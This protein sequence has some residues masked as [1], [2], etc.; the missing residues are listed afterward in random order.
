MMQ[1]HPIVV[2]LGTLATVTICT[3]I[4]IGLEYGPSYIA[5]C[6]E[7]PIKGFEVRGTKMSGQLLQT[8]AFTAALQSGSLTDR[9][10]LTIPDQD[11]TTIE[12]KKRSK[13]QCRDLTTPCT[14]STCNFFAIKSS[15][16]NTN[17]LSLENLQN[18]CQAKASLKTELCP[19]S[20]FTI[21]DAVASYNQKNCSYI[22][23]ADVD[24][25]VEALRICL[26]PYVA[27]QF[28]PTCD[29]NT[30]PHLPAPCNRAASSLYA[31]YFYFTNV[32]FR[33][34]LN[35]TNDGA[36]LIESMIVETGSLEGM[37]AY[38][39]LSSDNFEL[40]NGI[41]VQSISLGL[42][43]YEDTFA[44]YL[45]TDMIFFALA[46]AVI[47]FIMFLYLRS[48]LMVVGTV[49]SIVFAFIVAYLLYHYVFRFTFFPFLNVLSLLVLIAVGADD[50]F[51]FYDAWQTAKQH[52]YSQNPS[53]EP[54]GVENPA[55]SDLETAPHTAVN[56]SGSQSQLA[57]AAQKPHSFSVILSEFVMPEAFG[58]AI[59]SILVTS[60]TTAAAFASNYSSKIV[61]IRCFGIMGMSCILVNFVFMVTWIPA[62]VVCMELFDHNCMKV[63]ETGSCLTS[64]KQCLA[65][66]SDKIFGT[67]FPAM[68]SKAWFLWIIIFVAI[69]IWG[70]VLVFVTPTLQMP[71]SAD[72]QLFPDSNPFEKFR[73]TSE[74]YDF[75]RSKS[76]ETMHILFLFGVSDD[77]NSDHID[78]NSKATLQFVP[79]SFSSQASQISLQ[80]FCH[81]LKLQSW[82]DPNYRYIP[83]LFDTY[84]HQL[85]KPCDS[86]YP[87]QC[88]N[89]STHEIHDAFDDCFSHYVTQIEP[90][91]R[92][93]TPVYEINTNEMKAFYYSVQTTFVETNVYDDMKQWV[94]TLYNFTASNMGELNSGYFSGN[95]I[96]Y[97]LQ[98]QLGSGTWISLGISLGLSMI[99]MLITTLN[100]L[101]TIYAIFC[102]ALSIFATI[103]VLILMGWELSIVESAIL[104]L[105]V[106]LSIDFTIHYGVAYVQSSKEAQSE[107]V[108]ESFQ[109]VG[110][111]VTM[112]GLTTFVAGAMIM[113][114]HILAYRQLGTFLMLVMAIAWFFA[115]FLFQAMSSVLGPKK[116][117]LQLTCCKKSQKTDQ[118]TQNQQL[119]ASDFDQNSKSGNSSYVSHVT[120][121]HNGG[122][123]AIQGLPNQGFI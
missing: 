40:G 5:K 65:K 116:N 31:I 4:A 44:Y 107:R 57:P 72:L 45:G 98:D 106:G 79:V 32:D 22:S 112:A 109:R 80:S 108:K 13:T 20:V 96:F 3:G 19:E 77:D 88:C 24:N 99:I 64:C 86:N 12:R 104:T 10:S 21:A 63:C 49:T 74:A 59:R 15:T 113:P 55:F 105:A 118:H 42:A 123:V 52:Y 9:P 54:A 97:A 34:Q 7:D 93:G 70:I 46:M 2:L 81:E 89:L 62:F 73:K 56:H 117:F 14:E 114:S 121:Q 30:C 48:L 16:S 122:T 36:T 41:K 25:I 91:T 23:Q 35:T 43:V 87:R 33:E 17:L 100:V 84:F 61:V 75:V 115:T 28:G 92:Y 71:T 90:L 26:S 110:S 85:Q 53:T 68:V 51:V 39:D 119:A 37:D 111:S 29:Q 120:D 60:L 103:G 69:G 38:N 83:C 94:D 58:H 1:R 95:F 47:M 6:F 8:A 78:P 11:A 102:I 66:V 27:G 76:R 82:I 67:I 101:I 50:V 18:I